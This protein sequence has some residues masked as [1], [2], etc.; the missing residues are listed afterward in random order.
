MKRIL[1][2]AGL[3]VCLMSASPLKAQIADATV[4][5]VLASPQSFDGKIVRI[6]GVVVAGFEEFAIKG[7]GCNQ[8]LN[9]IWLDYPE[10]TNG[11]AGPAALLRLQLDKNHSA[12]VTNVNRAA[13]K[14]DKNKDFKDFDNL[15]STP[16]KSNGMCLGCVKFT[17]T[18]TLVGRLDGTN[19]AG[20]QR[21][22]AGK[23]IGLGGFGNANRYSARLVL[24]SVSDV[25]PQEIDYSKDGPATPEDTAHASRSFTP[26]AP[27]ADQVKRAVDA[28]GAPGED[29]GV[30]VGSSGANE[31]PKDD[32]AKSNAKSPDGLLFDVTF[33]GDRLKG[34]AMSIAMAHMGTHIADIRSPQSGIGNVTLYGAEFR[35]WQTCI[36][37][38]M[39]AKVKSVTLPGSYT[40]YSQ[41]WPNSD[42]GKNAYIGMTSF[43][44]NWASIVNPPKP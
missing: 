23:V 17:V 42:L 29:N 9:A 31:V 36:L 14:L 19:T 43:L 3:M 15:L 41:A 12:T 13:A 26:A 10:G 38:A 6:K 22:S 33:D 40:I 44:A 21:D 5:D 27:T 16:A 30:S 34:P 8:D 25:S 1:L 11:K 28:F 20:L 24:E 39:G 35:A 4:C 18:A 7:T 2:L 32:T 37:A